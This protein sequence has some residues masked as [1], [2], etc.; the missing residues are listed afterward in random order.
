MKIKHYTFF[1]DTHKIFLKHFLNSFPF[2]KDI[3]LVIRKMPQECESGVFVS[4]GWNK[5]MKRKVQYIVDSLSELEDGDIMIHTDADVVFMKPYK[6]ELLEELGDRDI[7]FQSDI[8]TA[9]MGVFAA[10][11][12]NKTKDFFQTV[13][14]E[15]ENHYHDQ[16]AVN[17]LL[18]NTKHNLN[19]GLFSHRFFNHGFFGKHYEGEDSVLFP[20]NMILLHANFTVGIERKLKLIKLALKTKNDQQ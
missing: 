18:K 17:F 20:T 6:S 19:V 10:R 15:L 12:S 14:N 3:D 4:D 13:N 16:E 8:G 9:C 1:T 2:D 5:T 11:V 7:V